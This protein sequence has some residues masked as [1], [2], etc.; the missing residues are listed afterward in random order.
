MKKHFDDKKIADPAFFKEGVLPAHSDHLWYESEASLASGES[1]L[2]MSLN[3]QW[4]FHYAKNLTQ[5][6][7]GFETDNCD[8]SGWDDITVPGHIELQ[9]YDIPRYINVAYP[10]DG[11]ED[12]DPGEIPVRYNPVGSY[13]TFFTVPQAMRNRPL[14]VSFGGVESGF[15][16]W[17][18]G[19]YVGYSEDSFSTSEFELTPYLKK[20]KNR[21]AVRVF[22]WTAGSWLEGQD[23]FRFSG[24]FRDVTLFALPRVHIYDLKVRTL[25]DDDYRDAVLEVTLQ[26]NGDAGSVSYALSDGA[27]TL[28]SGEKKAKTKTVLRIPVKEPVLWSAE[29]PYL[30]NL[31][32]RVR[33]TRG[34]MTEAVLQRVGFR[35]FE[36][37]DGIMC[38]NGRRI[39]FCGVNRHE[40]TSAHGRV[41]DF[42]VALQDVITMKQ[43]NINAVRTSHYPVASDLYHLCDAFGLYMI[44][45]TNMETHAMWNRIEMGQLA[46]DDALPGNRAAY[47]AALLDRANSNY[48]ANKNH[49]S[50]LIWSDGNESYG[51]SMIQAMTDFFRKAD[52][53]RLVHYEGITHDPRYPDMSDMYSQM[54]TPAAEAER[55]LKKHKD[56]PL[57]MC[58]FAHAMGNSCGA[59][60]KYTDLAM[61]NKRYQ[62]GFLWDLVDQ[63]IQKKNRYGESFLAYG[64]DHG[65]RVTDYAFSGNGILDGLR[66][67]Y[68]GK[69]Q[70]VKYC[71]RPLD[72]SV[73]KTKVKITNL[74]LFRSSGFYDCVVTLERNGERIQTDL[75]ETDVPPGAAK[76]YALPF[77]AQTQ[78]GEYAVN[79]SFYLR[80]DMPY[81]PKGHEVAYGQYVYR[82]AYSQK[83]EAVSAAPFRLVRGTLYTG[84]TGDGFE[85]LF[86]MTRGAIVSYRYHGR[87]LLA[88]I[89]RPNFWRAPTQN[90]AGNLMAYR[91]GT[92]KTASLYQTPVLPLDRSNP[93]QMRRL[94]KQA[95][96]NITIRE[97]K[98]YAEIGFVQYLPT[99]PETKIRVL[100]R[101]SGD[102]CVRVILD[103]K[104]DASLPPM[105][106]FGMLFKL[107]ADLSRLDWYGMGP[108]ENYC[109]RKSGARL[110][111]YTT[112]VA[113]NLTP[114]IVPQECGNR[115]GVRMAKLTG[116]D[117]RGILFSAD[118]MEFS[119]LPYTPEQLEE[120]QHPYELPPVHF[121]V[122]RCMLSQMGIAGDDGWGARTHPEYLLPTGK[123]LHF[124]M[125]FRGI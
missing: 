47:R 78:P 92:W 39:V 23:F 35:R 29:N 20:G 17:C 76:S 120:A 105:P 109:D 97:T 59:M 36:M 25:L 13:V 65:E 6:P 60:H 49:P 46:P 72:I 104:P 88:Q 3:G 125:A 108:A 21:L 98:E 51:G 123:A 95:Q 119:A 85:V 53:D 8:V 31:V 124:E 34:N 66:R 67:P 37:K 61:R 27:E 62:G 9:G 115:T 70:E 43:N 55:F 19:H 100:Y 30:Y 58:E 40:F 102:G 110:G 74:H 64:G 28:L 1:S 79:V 56:K 5:A 4:K 10:W 86:S 117:G 93:A 114:Y 63:V 87:E 32:L 18:N 48:Q 52:P 16:L 68:E 33:D 73:T 44:A 89:P 94:M 54:Y 75:L 2:R 7:A 14:Y 116:A 82:I 121:T 96:N 77:A 81:A 69:M 112:D 118:E 80:E 38:L 99:T 71:Y 45:E 12:L 106:E 50:V 11:T 91:Y 41:P 83:K 22:R 15:A 42:E 84:V 122:V 111:I 113:D 24:I 103:M 57:I 26:I 107:D 101:V 90:D